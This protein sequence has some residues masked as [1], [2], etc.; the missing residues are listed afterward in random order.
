MQN[1]GFIHLF[2]FGVNN[3][4]LPESTSLVNIR[5]KRMKQVRLHFA[6]TQD[7]FFFNMNK[8]HTTGSIIIIVDIY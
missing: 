6:H 5:Q 4:Q 7:T 8:G 1:R 3:Y 2:G